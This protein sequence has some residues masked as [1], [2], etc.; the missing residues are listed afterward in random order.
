MIPE[1]VSLILEIIG[2]V[3]FAVSGAFVAIKAGLD[4]FGVAFIGVI[5]AMGGGVIR[6]ILI[7]RFPPAV[8]LNFGVF[9][10]AAAVSVAVFAV[11]FFNRHR[12]DE[13]REKIEHINNFFD[14]IGLAAF[15]VMGT[16]VAFTTDFGDNMFLAV[17]MGMLTG[18]GGGIFRDILTDTTPYV[19]KKHIYAIASILGS[20][21]YYV[22]RRYFGD[23]IVASAACMIFVVTLR[24]F[25]AHY[26]WSLPKVELPEKDTFGNK[27]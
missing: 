15:S 23:V 3:S 22:I 20:V 16:E 1:T 6:D 13:L 11:A 18:V 7:G 8:F 9:A 10:V 26:R 25:A 4:I 12:F 2:T 5:T 24:M 19:F 14:A 27:K 17:V 21:L